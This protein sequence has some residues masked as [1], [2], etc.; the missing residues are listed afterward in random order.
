M[1]VDYGPVLLHRPPVI[2]PGQRDDRAA[3]DTG[4]YPAVRGDGVEPGPDLDRHGGLL[5]YRRR[6][7]AGWRSAECHHRFQQRRQERRKCLPRCWRSRINFS[8]RSN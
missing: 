7:D 5:Q 4:D 6:D 1:A 3:N 2:D 8:P